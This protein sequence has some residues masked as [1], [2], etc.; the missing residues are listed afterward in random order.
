MAFTTLVLLGIP[1]VVLFVT[2]TKSP[3]VNEDETEA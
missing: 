2:F 3:K 1:I